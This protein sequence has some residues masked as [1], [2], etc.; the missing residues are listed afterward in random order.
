[1][2]SDYLAG[3]PVTLDDLLGAD[4]FSSAT[5]W[6]HAIAVIA[7][8]V[9]FLVWLRRARH[10]AE[11]L[12]LADHRKVHGWVIGAWI[13]PV[14]NLWFPFMI[15]D[16]VY[17]ASRPTNPTNLT[18]LRTVPGSP[19]LETWWT[20]WLAVTLANVVGIFMG[21]GVTADSFRTVAIFSTI[22]TALLIGAAVM[23]II[24]MREI[25]RWQTP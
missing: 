6:G 24:V 1:V 2:V 21:R 20:L 8:G 17:R 9:V 25:S 10:N 18:D 11:I 12:C 22:S 3:G 23:I 5:F 13:C 7:A 19:V 15:M 16:D 14:A 4:R